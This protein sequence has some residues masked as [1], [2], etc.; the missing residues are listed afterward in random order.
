MLFSVWDT[1]IQKLGFLQKTFGYSWILAKIVLI[2]E[3][4]DPL[5][6]KSIYFLEKY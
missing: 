6:I 4:R 5:I 2:G 3:L 1:Y